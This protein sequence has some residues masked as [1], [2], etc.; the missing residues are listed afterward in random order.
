MFW[1]TVQ[2]AALAAM[3]GAVWYLYRRRFPAVQAVSEAAVKG[4]V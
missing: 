4:E 1:M 2:V 3:L